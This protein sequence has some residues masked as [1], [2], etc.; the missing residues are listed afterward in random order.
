MNKKALI[1][2]NSAISVEEEPIE[3]ITPG[4]FFVEEDGS[5][6]V[7]YDETKISG[8]EGTKTRMIIKEDS[9]ELLR[10]GSTETKMMFE[11]HKESVSL[12]KTPYGAMAVTIYTNKIDINVTEDG[13]TVDISY[14]LDI[15]EQQKV[16][17]ILKVTIKA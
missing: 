2:V 5:F 10:S 17:T 3:V 15:E 16:D 6:T 14:S 7:E 9:F 4:D 13:G 1:T 11:K 12:Y 8:M